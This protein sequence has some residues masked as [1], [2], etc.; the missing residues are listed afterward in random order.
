MEC[1]HIYC[2]A[3]CSLKLKS[4]PIDQKPIRKRYKFILCDQFGIQEQLDDFRK[5]TLFEKLFLIPLFGS[6]KSINLQALPEAILSKRDEYLDLKKRNNN[7]R[8][9]FICVGCNKANKQTLFL[10]C[11]HFAYCDPCAKKFKTCPFDQTKIE[12]RCK[13]FIS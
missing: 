10:D 3:Q 8:Q 1:G 4:C 11:C 2:C 5:G 6:L 7:Y 13:G 12:K 9:Y